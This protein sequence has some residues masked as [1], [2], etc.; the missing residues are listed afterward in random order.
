MGLS[1]RWFLVA[2]GDTLYLLANTRFDRMLR[3]PGLHLLP[4]LAGQRVR[5]VSVVVEIEGRVPVRV[6]MRYFG[7]LDVDSQGRID[8]D[9]FLRQQGARAETSPGSALGGSQVNG[10]ILDASARFIAR[11]GTWRPTK[12]MVDAIDEV[13][14]GL[15]KCRRL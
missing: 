11:G 10:P 12:T 8:A 3:D 13:A 1:Y 7:M 15:R 9:L 2:Q 14:L 5:T 6:R 4:A